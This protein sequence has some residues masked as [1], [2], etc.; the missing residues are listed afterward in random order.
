MCKFKIIL[1]ETRPQKFEVL[2]LISAIIS[3]MLN[4]L[5]VLFLDLLGAK[6]FFLIQY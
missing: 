1:R 6:L 5:I 4:V 2:S 3:I